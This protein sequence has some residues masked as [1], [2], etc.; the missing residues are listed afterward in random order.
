MALLTWVF[1]QM[2]ALR[3]LRSCHNR[4]LR[5]SPNVLISRVLHYIFGN[6]FC[7]A[8]IGKSWQHAAALGLERCV[9]VGIN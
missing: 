3:Q 5:E 6:K 9:G 4:S 2:S 7:S 8:Q 1:F